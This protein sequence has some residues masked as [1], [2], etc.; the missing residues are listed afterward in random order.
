MRVLIGVGAWGDES[1]ARVQADAVAAW[2]RTAPRDDVH[3]LLMADG[4]P[5]SADLF[6]GSPVGVGPVD[7]L[8]VG[9]AIV[10]LPADAARRWDPHA[11]REGLAVLAAAQTDDRRPLTVVVPLGDDDPAGDAVD[12]WGADRDATRAALRRLDIV[13]LVGSDRPLL[14]LHG[15]SASVRVGREADLALA[16]ATQEGE[17]RWNAI[18]AEAER[19][20]P[21]GTL[22]GHER[23]ADRHGAGAAAGLAYCLSVVGAR[24]APAARYCAG[25][26]QFDDRALSADLVLAIATTLDPAQIDRGTVAAAAAA[27]SRG[28]VPCAA[29]AREVLVGRRDLMAGGIASAHEAGDAP[30]GVIVERVARTWSPDRNG[31]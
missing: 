20:L 24:L 22:L 18:A 10:L 14:G 30:L 12:V 17:R 19:S 16:A 2:R 23:L 5:R 31:G 13:A 11:L 25:L 28:G 21:R 3:S 4:G 15:M 27:A 1:P 8:R 6:D 9:N 7:S 26:S 29:V